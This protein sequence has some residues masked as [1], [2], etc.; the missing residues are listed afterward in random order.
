LEWTKWWKSLRKHWRKI[1]EKQ[2]ENSKVN[3]S[4]PSGKITTFLYKVQTIFSKSDEY[5]RN[6]LLFRNPEAFLQGWLI[7]M[8]AMQ[9]KKCDVPPAARATTQ[10]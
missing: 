1:E 9:S 5:C 6:F 4:L 8:V 7:R 10:N 2:R 3:A